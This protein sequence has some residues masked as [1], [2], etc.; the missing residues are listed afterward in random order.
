MSKITKAVKGAFQRTL[1]RQLDRLL[2]KVLDLG[3]FVHVP[4]DARGTIET[5]RL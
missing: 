4:R 2:A 5:G 1:E 3:A